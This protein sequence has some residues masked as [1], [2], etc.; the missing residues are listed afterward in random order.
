M[1][2]T[3]RRVILA[4]PLVAVS[5]I[6]L[7]SCDLLKAVRETPGAIKQPDPPRVTVAGVTLIAAPTN[8]Q[9]TGYY[10]AQVANRTV[11]NFMGAEVPSQDQLKFVFDVNLDVQ[12]P[13][14]VPIPMVEALAA[15]TAFP[16]AQG[17]QNLGA[18]CLSMCDDPASCPQNAADACNTQ[19][20]QIRTMQDF[21]T[22]AAGFL[23]ATA[24]GQASFDN[25]KIKTIPANGTSRV[26]FRLEL[27]PDSVL[28]LI[29]TVATDAID[30][31]KGGK[32]P[33]FSIPFQVEGTV[34][35]QVEGFGRIAA[36]FPVFKHTW[37]LV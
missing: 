35:I 2:R 36:P 20:P 9:L 11:C 5:L 3:L 19:A 30:Q 22:A 8:E 29:K 37:N 7:G 10:C 1:T 15:F 32:V 16:D 21:A 17:Q 24:T 18:L 14:A 25:L 23:F 4:I 33:T 28:S 13:N 12:N 26:T 34:W 27:R 6:A 31:V